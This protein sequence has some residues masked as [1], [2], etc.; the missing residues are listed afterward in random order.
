M[1]TT[2]EQ[3]L[4]NTQEKLAYLRSKENIQSIIKENPA[5][6]RHL[7]IEEEV[8]RSLIVS[9]KRK[10]EAS[11]NL[12]FNL[13]AL[14]LFCFVTITAICLFNYTNFAHFTWEQQLSELAMQ[15]GLITISILTFFLFLS[16]S[17]ARAKA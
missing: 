1:N 11:L 3:R 7:A 2:V 15:F 8:L 14:F 9:R 17:R 13:F 6:L 10:V 16:Q 5:Q 12:G 4:R